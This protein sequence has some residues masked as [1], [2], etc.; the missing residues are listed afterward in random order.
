M[1]DLLRKAQAARIPVQDPSLPKWERLSSGL[2]AYSGLELTC[3][4]GDV[5]E[6]LE[7]DFVRVNQR[8]GST[9][10]RPAR[11]ISV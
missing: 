2:Q 7:A 1:S 11:T 4:P 10:W 6:R 3:L 5:R 8:R 9:R